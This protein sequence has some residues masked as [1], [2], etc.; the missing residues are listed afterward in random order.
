MPPVFTVVFD[1][2]IQILLSVV[3]YRPIDQYKTSF[4]SYKKNPKEH[5][6][7]KKKQNPQPPT[8]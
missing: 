4:Q 2:A 7:P 3:Q 6:P 1:G 8:I 5:L